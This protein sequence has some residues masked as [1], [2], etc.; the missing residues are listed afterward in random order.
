MEDRKKLRREKIAD[1]CFIYC[2]EKYMRMLKLMAVYELVSV[3]EMGRYIIR[4]TFDAYM[5]IPEFKDF[6]D[7]LDL[8]EVLDEPDGEYRVLDGQRKREIFGRRKKYKK[9]ED[10]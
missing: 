7:K 9:K 6:V 8:T 4:N 10:K 1:E 2:K 5:Q 3:S